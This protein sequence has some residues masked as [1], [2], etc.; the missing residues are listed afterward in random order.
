MDRLA[1][2]ALEIYIYITVHLRIARIISE[3]A[4]S[5][6]VVVRR[7][8]VNKIRPRTLLKDEN[9]ILVTRDWK[10]ISLFS[11][12]RETRCAKFSARDKVD[13]WTR[14]CIPQNRRYI[15]RL[16]HLFINYKYTV[17]RKASVSKSMVAFRNY[18]STLLRTTR[19]RAHTLT[20]GTNLSRRM[21]VKRSILNARITSD[22]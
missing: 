20:V 11:L 6:I 15:A 10:I 5:W 1:R 2:G 12:N 7:S 13:S 22:L 17:A 8:I 14:G 4:N 3:R 9:N 19:A 16:L 21:Q 18:G